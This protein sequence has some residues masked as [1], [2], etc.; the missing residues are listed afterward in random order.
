MSKKL[1]HKSNEYPRPK[2]NIILVHHY[3]NRIEVR[4][5]YIHENNRYFSMSSFEKLDWL[6]YE[7][8]IDKWC[9][10]EDLLKIK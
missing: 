10:I 3:Y 8:K 9:Y 6:R 7:W 2:S 4:D 5:A 1:W